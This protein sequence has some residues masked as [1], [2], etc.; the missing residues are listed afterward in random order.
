MDFCTK[1]VEKFYLT[2]YIDT[3]SSMNKKYD[4]KGRD[5]DVICTLSK[6]HDLQ[7]RKEVAG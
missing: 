5:I 6:M 2:H 1:I 3:I 7:A 4:K